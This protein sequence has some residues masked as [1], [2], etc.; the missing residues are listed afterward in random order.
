[1]HA[2]PTEYRSLP[3]IRI[4]A[5]GATALV[6]LHGAHVLSWRPADGRERLFLSERAV[7][8]GRAAIRGGIPV[9]FPQFGERGALARHGFARA[10]AWRY[11]GI[12]GGGAVFELSGDGGDPAWPHPFR[13][14]LRIALA[15]TTL[16]LALEIEN[17]GDDAFAFSAALHTYLRVDEIAAVAIEG[18]HG[19]DFEDSANGGSL[20][21]Q[22]DHDV[23]FDDETDR[24]YSDVVAPL[25]LVEGERRLAIEQDG[26][27]D[28]IV[29]NPGQRLGARIGDLAADD[30]RRFA[31]VE[32]G[33][34]LQPVV[35]AP[36]ESWRGRQLL[37]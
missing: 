18:L 16:A 29:W 5:E 2:E 6:A 34:V 19:C 20:H 25:A 33:Q 32:A 13:A 4:D 24:I 10:T 30:W 35:L 12:E 27:A 8:D 15:A 17:T 26:F 22:H 28:A 7:F 31:C 23:R 3:C 36:G 11:A 14:R 1:M 21:R 9:I 37:G